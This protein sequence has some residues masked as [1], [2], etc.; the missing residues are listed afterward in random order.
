MLDSV[1]YETNRMDFQRKTVKTIEVYTL[2]VNIQL[3]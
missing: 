3:I 2:A 1:R